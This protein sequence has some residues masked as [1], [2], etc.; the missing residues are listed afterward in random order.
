[1]RSVPAR[2]CARQPDLRAQVC[3]RAL[4]AHDGGDFKAPE[5]SSPTRRSS[6]A[7]APSRGKEAILAGWK[8]F[9]DGPMPPF[10]WRPEVVEVLPSGK[11]A[12]SSGPIM[13][14]DGKQFGVFNSIWRLEAD[15]RWRVVFD[16]GCPVC[17]PE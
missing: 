9:F 6:S 15:G 4:R 1:M 16:K 10:S 14:D 13:G 11:L 7:G 3:T 2:A 5:R 12:H 17:G 8:P